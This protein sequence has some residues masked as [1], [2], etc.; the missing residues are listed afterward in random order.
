MSVFKEVP[1]VKEP[2]EQ[3][4]SSLKEMG[5]LLLEY[6]EGSGSRFLVFRS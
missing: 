5:L 2:T 1:G 6:A 4:R 3:P